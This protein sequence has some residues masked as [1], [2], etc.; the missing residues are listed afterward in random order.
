MKAIDV[1]AA[2]VEDGD[3]Y[4]VTRR[5]AGIHLAGLWEFPGGKVQPAETHQAAL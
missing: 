2:V 1:V 5:Q 3:R 4:L